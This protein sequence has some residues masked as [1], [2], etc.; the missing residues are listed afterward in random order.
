MEEFQQ[1]HAELVKK[2]DNTYNEI[3][4]IQRQ[5]ERLKQKV[6]LT[7]Y[8]IQHNCI[9]HNRERNMPVDHFLWLIRIDRSN[10]EIFMSQ[11]TGTISNTFCN[12]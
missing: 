1:S 8:T 7:E 9:K 12:Q 2:R 10:L 3:I 11:T 4:E 6:E 5:L